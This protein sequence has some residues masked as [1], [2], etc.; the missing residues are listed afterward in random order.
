MK[1]MW[2]NGNAKTGE[3]ISKNFS[4]FRFHYDKNEDLG[5]KLIYKFSWNFDGQHGY[6][7]IM[8]RKEDNKIS[9][10]SMIGTDNCSS[11]P[12]DRALGLYNDESLGTIFTGLLQGIG[13]KVN[14]FYS[15]PL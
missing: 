15:E 10:S 4:H 5:D 9:N 13:V 8:V 2:L 14:G 3:K 7:S 11:H 1:N 6:I 12:F